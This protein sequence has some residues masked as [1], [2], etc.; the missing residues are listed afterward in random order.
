MAKFLKN[1]QQERGFTLIELIIVIF[2]MGILLGI[3]I[4]IYKTHVLRAN[5]AVLKEDLSTMRQAIDQFT[6]DKQRAPQALEDLV[7]AGYLRVVPID[8]FTHT[9]DWVTVSEDSVMSVDQTQPGLSDVH[10]NAPGIGTDGTS[11]GSW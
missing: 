2:I 9:A 11:Y 3:A 7:A 6:Q 10:S 5:E 4:P 8:P 1:R